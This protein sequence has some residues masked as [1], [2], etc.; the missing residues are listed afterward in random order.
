MDRIDQAIDNR[1]LRGDIL[2]AAWLHQEALGGPLEYPILRRAM[3][4]RYP[5]LADKN[6]KAQIHFLQDRKL[7]EE[8]VNEDLPLEL[9]EMSEGVKLTRAGK[10]I[11]ER[12]ADIGGVIISR[13]GR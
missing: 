4:V 8:V 2:E 6:L 3:M 1:Y 12:D 7:V 9:Q 10:A 11:V 5:S 13:Q